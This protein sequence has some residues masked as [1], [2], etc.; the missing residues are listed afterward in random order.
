[1]P[2]QRVTLKKL[3]TAVRKQCMEC[4][5]GQPGLVEDCTSP[6]CSLYPYRFGY[7]SRSARN[8]LKVG[9]TVASECHQTTQKQGELI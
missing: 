9:S 4:M 3:W 1:M 2:K 6:K 5:G 7:S 8:P